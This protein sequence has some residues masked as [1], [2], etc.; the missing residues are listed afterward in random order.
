MCQRT[1]RILW[2]TYSVNCMLAVASQTRLGEYD[3][4]LDCGANK[5]VFPETQCLDAWNFSRVNNSTVRAQTA[6]VTCFL[7]S[8]SKPS[9]GTIRT[10]CR[11]RTLL[12]LRLDVQ[13]V[14]PYRSQRS[15]CFY[16]GILTGWQRSSSSFARTKPRWALAQV[17]PMLIAQ[18]SFGLSGAVSFRA[19]S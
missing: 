17:V 6:S 8:I 10:G 4:A 3:E 1:R 16:C 13:S 9:P 7:E 15:R 19:L 12:G 11:L 18:A 5:L 2:A 14:P